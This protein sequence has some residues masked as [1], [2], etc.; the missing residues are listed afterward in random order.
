MP[1]LQIWVLLVWQGHL[2]SVLHLLLVLLKNCLVD[3]DFRRSEGRCG[4]EF[5]Q[6]GQPSRFTLSM[7][8]SLTHQSLVTD[9]LPGEPEERLLEVVVGLGRNVVVLEV[10]LA[11]EGDG[12]GLDLALLH[13]DL[14]SSEDD[15]DVLA[16][17]DEVT[18]SCD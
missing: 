8:R 18:W 11:V 1:R 6:S 3:L 4:N 7:V 10:L 5:L 14:V 2:G 16:H 13:V 15:W 17:T 9:K 12:L